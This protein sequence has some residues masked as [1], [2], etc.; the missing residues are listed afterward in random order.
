MRSR[1]GGV[2]MTRRLRTCVLWLFVLVACVDHPASEESP[3][4]DTDPIGLG[5]GGGW[6][7]S[8]C[9]GAAYTV[10]LIDDAG[11]RVDL[12]QTQAI[13]IVAD[14]VR[15][16]SHRNDKDGRVVM[17]RNL[18]RFLA[19]GLRNW[20]HKIGETLLPSDEWISAYDPD[21][22]EHGSGHYNLLGIRDACEPIDY[23]P[24]PAVA[25]ALGMFML[26]LSQMSS[27]PD[28]EMAEKSGNFVSV[29]VSMH[30]TD[31]LARDLPGA[32]PAPTLYDLERSWT[33]DLIAPGE[34]PDPDMT[35][36]LWDTSR[37]T[38]VAPAFYGVQ[39]A[40]VP[41]PCLAQAQIEGFVGRVNRVH[42]SFA[43]GPAGEPVAFAAPTVLV[44][45][46]PLGNATGVRH[47]LADYHVGLI[48]RID[49]YT[50][51]DDPGYFP[52]G[53]PVNP[54]PAHLARWRLRGADVVRRPGALP[55]D[56]DAALAPV[57][58][59]RRVTDGI[60]VAIPRTASPKCLRTCPPERA[61]PTGG[62]CS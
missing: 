16:E 60:L 53:S 4:D 30:P 36:I 22:V 14:A 18:D 34:A 3:P 40:S 41:A 12:R 5:G 19:V 28:P 15:L 45:T 27:C 23:Q 47:F 1:I 20:Q 31:E 62:T 26:A 52:Y 11:R 9:M 24:T 6:E 42:P 13:G 49:G 48:T 44:G 37:A 7:G 33:A 58:E 43:S 21:S 35:C 54:C 10:S 32:P 50:T 46:D 38:A 29:E 56:L 59:R 57:F 25:R 39:E 8:N 61:S 17:I 55:P 2:Q 51:C